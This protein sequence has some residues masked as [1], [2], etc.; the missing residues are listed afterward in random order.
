MEPRTLEVCLSPALFPFR[1]TGER[2]ITLVIDVLR[3]STSVIAAFDFGVRKVIPTDSLLQAEVLKSEGLL[4]AA[5]RDGEKLPFADFGNG[6][7]DFNVPEIVGKTLAYSTTNGTKALLLAQTAGPVGML[8]FTNM[9]A[10]LGWIS[11]QYLPV[12]L[13]CSGWKNQPAFEDT[14][15]AGAFV[16]AILQDSSFEV[17]C[18]SARLAL[19]LWQ[20]IKSDPTAALQK[21]AHYKRLIKLGIDPDLEYTL[22]ESSSSSVPVIEDDVLVNYIFAG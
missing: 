7:R 11:G 2:H 5:E 14:A 1:K 10:A 17:D 22:N 9:K 12:V 4:V 20:S 3:F 6:A 15:C 8:A 16:E 13:L 21:T 19:L 18:D